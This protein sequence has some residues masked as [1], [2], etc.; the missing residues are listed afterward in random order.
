MFLLPSLDVKLI[1][2]L[3]KLKPGSRIV[4]HSFAMGEIRPDKVITMVSKEDQSEHTIY[5]WITALKKETDEQ[6]PAI[7]VK[8][9]L[10]QPSLTGFCSL[11]D[12]YIASMTSTALRAS[13]PSIQKSSPDS[14]ASRNAL[15]FRA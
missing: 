15:K 4:S 14:R 1:P 7:D 12:L 3:Q 8:F 13:R 9:M 11:A 10:H 6:Q 5:L 2:Q